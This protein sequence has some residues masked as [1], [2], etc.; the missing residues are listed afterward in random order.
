M[1]TPKM[2]RSLAACPAPPPSTPSPSTPTPGW[3]W[4]QDQ[5]SRL[6]RSDGLR[7]FAGHRDRDYRAR[8]AVMGNIRLPDRWRCGPAYDPSWHGTPDAMAGSPTCCCSGR[9][10]IWPLLAYHAQF[11]ARANV[12]TG[13]APEA[14]P[15]RQPILGLR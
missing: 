14:S 2:V 10:L 4:E 11:G 15:K 3:S 6:V 9:Y 12:L 13:P 5:V 8:L 7:G 1:R